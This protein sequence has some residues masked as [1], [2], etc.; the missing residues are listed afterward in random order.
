[1]IFAIKNTAP[2]VFECA[3]D[4]IPGY[5]FPA[6]WWSLGCCGYEMLCGQRPY[7][8]HST[9]PL[10]QV[11]AMQRKPCPEFPA[12]ITHSCQHMIQRLLNPDPKARISC[13]GDLKKCSA[14]STMSFEA[15]LRRAVPPTFVPPKDQLNC[16][17]T[18]ELEEM[19]I[20]ANPLH[21]KKKRLQKQQS[22]RRMNTVS[23]GGGAGV[24][25]Q[26]S[27]PMFSETGAGDEVELSAVEKCLESIHQQF[28]VYNR[29][30]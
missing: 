21:K 8:I 25:R 28:I 2:E 17:P 24:E 4:Y 5:S 10:D 18:F 30:K 22:M 23:S 20:E 9:T 29:E 6:D 1:M 15:A 27:S 12:H 19:I 26:N 7:D 14:Y 16:D 13:I 11:L 3:L